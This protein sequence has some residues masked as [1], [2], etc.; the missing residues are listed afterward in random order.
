MYVLC[1]SS[2]STLPLD[3]FIL[4][5]TK[6]SS[7]DFQSQRFIEKYKFTRLLYFQTTCIIGNFNEIGM[8]SVAFA[9]NAMAFWKGE[10]TKNFFFHF[11]CFS[12]FN[13]FLLVCSKRRKVYLK[14]TYVWAFGFAKLINKTIKWLLFSLKNPRSFWL[15]HTIMV[16]EET[17]TIIIFFLKYWQ[18]IL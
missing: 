2:N 12:P 7:L 10:D 3:F 17:N 13:F 8:S 16:F 6:I 14:T 1:T 11:V 15:V 5:F 4:N 18:H 9:P